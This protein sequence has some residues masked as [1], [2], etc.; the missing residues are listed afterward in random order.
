MG[1]SGVCECAHQGSLV[2][3]NWYPELEYLT[4]LALIFH[5][6][7]YPELKNLHT[8]CNKNMKFLVRYVMVTQWLL[9][10]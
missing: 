4:T 10:R 8:I 1:T 2:H 6:Y 5:H 3:H 9:M 7:W